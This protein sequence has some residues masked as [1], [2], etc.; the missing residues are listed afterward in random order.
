MTWD[1][2]GT[3]NNARWIG[4]G[5]WAGKTTVASILA[6]RYGLTVYRHDYPAARSHLDRVAAAQARVG[7]P[8]TG[9]DPDWAFVQRSPQEMA[10]GVLADFTDRFEWALDDLR[11]LESPHPIIAEGWGLRPELVAGIG[12]AGR[13]VVLVP[14]E[15]FRQHQIATLPRASQLGNR[16][17]NQ[18]SDPGLGQRNRVDRDRLMAEDAVQSAVRHGVP[19]IKVDG[20]RDADG[21]ADLVA[22]P[23]GLA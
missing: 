23:L 9:F 18:V 8:V 14:T 20:S 21:V 15:K 22:G 5:Q 19:V 13:M 7:E 2:L 10:A 11:A 1:P 3:I 17:R 16:N 6:R 12:G 4:G